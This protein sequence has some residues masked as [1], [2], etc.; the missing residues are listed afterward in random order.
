LLDLPGTTSSGN[1]PFRTA[2]SSFQQRDATQMKPREHIKLLDPSEV[3]NRP[4]AQRTRGCAPLQTTFD[5]FPN[6]N[7]CRAAEMTD[8]PSSPSPFVLHFLATHAA[9]LPL[10]SPVEVEP[11]ECRRPRRSR[12]RRRPPITF[13]T[14]QSGF[15]RQILLSLN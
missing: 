2:R 9:S 15:G 1:S 11:P 12:R 13:S 6:F 14:N 7:Q 3:K 10:R 8:Y 4:A 5:T